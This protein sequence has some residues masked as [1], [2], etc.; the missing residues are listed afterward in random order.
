MLEYEVNSKC[1]CPMKVKIGFALSVI[2]LVTA[3]TPVVTRRA[4]EQCTRQFL[5]TE[6]T[7]P[8]D[9]TLQTRPVYGCAPT[10]SQATAARE[11]AGK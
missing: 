8:R 10:A 1:R 7:Y 6:Y 5:Y 11:H 3:C 2:T 4:A 9:G